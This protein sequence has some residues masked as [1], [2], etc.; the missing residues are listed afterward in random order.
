MSVNIIK[1]RFQEKI[2]THPVEAEV[3]IQS[4]YWIIRYK[5]SQGHTQQVS[6][7]ED[8]ISS[9]D[10]N[11]IYTVKG[12]AYPT[13]ISDHPTLSRRSKSKSKIN[14]WIKKRSEAAFIL[15]AAFIFIVLSLAIWKTV[16]MIANAIAMRIPI[17]TEQKLG[18]EMQ[19]VFLAE[20]TIDSA[21][22][23]LVNEYADSLQIPSKYDLQFQVVPSDQVNAFA[24][25]GGTIV[26]YSEMIKKMNRHEALAALIG[27]E[28][29]HIEHRHS[30]KSISRSLA[31]ST[32]LSMILGGS[33]A[34]S[35]IFL[36]NVNNLT[37]LKYSRALE[38]EADEESIRLMKNKKI[39][40]QGMI[41]LMNALQQIDTT[42]H[43]IEFLQTHP[44]T[45]HRMAQALKAAKT[46]GVPILHTG[47]E[48]I[49]T[50]IKS[51][52]E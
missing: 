52:L 38:H 15:S 9:T 27:H 22:T 34:L 26:I 13:L 21:L 39:D 23:I 50:K 14:T 36:K 16:P 51:E 41:E 19:K 6:W 11:I 17:E 30:L 33:D 45:E 35:G 12:E 37:G 42:G 10:E 2:T 7:I 20:Y 25:P 46:Q 1:G 31:W 44:L 24:I 29:T 40:L 48:D 47:L 3:L 43:P 18:Y 8:D 49:W 28:A 32:T 4:G 5:D